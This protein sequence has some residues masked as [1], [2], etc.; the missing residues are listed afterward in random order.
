MS[1]AS[2]LRGSAAKVILIGLLV[3]GMVMIAIGLLTP[4]PSCKLTCVESSGNN[5]PVAVVGAIFAVAAVV[6]LLSR[7][8][9]R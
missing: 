3:L 4:G 6:A 9:R 1:S 5:Y 8:R 7:G 2:I